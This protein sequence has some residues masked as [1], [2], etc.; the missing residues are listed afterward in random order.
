VAAEKDILRIDVAVQHAVGMRVAECVR[1]V[2]ED[3]DG[4]C[5]GDGATGTESRA[6]RIALDPRHHVVWP[7]LQVPGPDHG[8]DVGLLQPRCERDLARE[9]LRAHGRGELGGKYLRHH[10]PLELALP[11][12]EH[13]R[14]ARTRELALEDVAGAEGLQQ[15]VV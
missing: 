15:P 7:T 6:E 13:T 4:I 11:D 12:E 8:N 9:P 1:E 10:A 3:G 5:D 14:H 2:P